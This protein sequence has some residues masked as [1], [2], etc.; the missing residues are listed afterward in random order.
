MSD[1]EVFMYDVRVRERF[2]SEGTITKADVERHLAAIADSAANSEDVDLEQPALSKDIDESTAAPTLVESP[3]LASGEAFG[4][5]APEVQRSAAIPAIAEPG[6]P[7]SHASEPRSS[8]TKQPIPAVAQDSAAPAGPSEQH[9]PA[10][11]P[12][13]TASV[14]ADWGDS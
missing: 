14:D 11:V 6:A 7:G 8:E 5:R 1:R 13:P 4:S 10:S 12:P 9:G 3:A 2:L